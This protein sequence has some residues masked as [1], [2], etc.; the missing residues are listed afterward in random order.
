M[1]INAIKVNIMN[2]D[3]DILNQGLSL[4]LEWGEHWLE[5][6]QERLGAIYSHL[7]K[8]ELDKYNSYCKKVASDG[9]ALIF[10]IAYGDGKDCYSEESR[11]SW[12]QGMLGKYPWINEENLSHS[13]SQSC[14]YALK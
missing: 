5:T 12:R 6:I 1:A 14:Y 7:S 2:Y 9:N 8:E 3:N 4:A 10:K 13:Y 11:Q